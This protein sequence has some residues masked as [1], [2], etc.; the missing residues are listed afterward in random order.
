MRIIVFMYALVAPEPVRP[1]G[2]SRKPVRPLQTATSRE[3]YEPEHSHHSAVKGTL[4]QV[5]S[6]I[7][8]NK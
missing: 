7:N 6:A 3:K 4:L 1:L 5:L 2:K 8:H